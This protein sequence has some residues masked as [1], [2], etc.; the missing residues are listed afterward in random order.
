MNVGELCDL[1][2]CMRV[3]LFDADAALAAE[4]NDP[5]LQC[6]LDASEEVA[7]DEEKLLL[8]VV[9]SHYLRGN[10]A[11]V[12]E[13]HHGPHEHFLQAILGDSVGLHE[14]SAVLAAPDHL[15][16]EDVRLD[17]GVVLED[18]V[19]VDEDESAELL[20]LW[21][22]IEGFV[23]VEGLELLDLLDAVQLPHSLALRLHCPQVC[24][25]LLL[26]AHLADA[27]SQDLQETVLV[28]AA[29][30]DLLEADADDEHAVAF[31]GQ[32]VLAFDPF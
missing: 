3:Q 14:L 17:V 31:L 29:A 11:D 23:D 9:F 1:S 21:A 22:R 5:L 19:A 24:R 26:V 28:L 13:F 4:L 16:V 32:D 18:I 27:Q 15:G 20:L 6:L 8:S 7:F 30:E 10:E 25:E 12:A 2:V